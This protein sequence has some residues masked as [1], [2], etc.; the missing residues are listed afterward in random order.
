MDGDSLHQRLISAYKLLY[1]KGFVHS[2]SEFANLIGKQV[3]HVNA[4]FKNAPKRCT[5]GL[6]KAIA[7]AFSEVLNRDYLLTG[8][9]EVAA[10]DRSMRP[11]YDAKASAGTLSGFSDGEEGTMM[12]RIPGMAD[13]DFTINASGDSMLPRIESGDLLA[14]R[15]RDDR[16]NPPIGKICVIDARDGAAVKV[17]ESID[18]ESIRLHSLNPDYDDYSVDLSDIYGISQVVGLVRHF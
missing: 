16:A 1:D 13:Y 7:D 14:C 5:L 17:V 11:H 18:S 2:Q 3:T 9:G 10:P 12:E 15:R 4:A 6:M 8:E